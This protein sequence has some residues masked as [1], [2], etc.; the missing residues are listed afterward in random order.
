MNDWTPITETELLLRLEE[1][2]RELSSAERENFDA[3]KVAVGTRGKVVQLNS[4]GVEFVFIVARNGTKVVFFDDVE[5]EFAA[6]TIDDFGVI[7]NAGLF[8]ELRSAL[9]SLATA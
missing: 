1:G 8:G 5:D 6:G 3:W 7:T 4:D 2:E 9:R